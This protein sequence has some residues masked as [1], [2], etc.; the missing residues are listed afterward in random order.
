MTIPIYFFQVGNAQISIPSTN[1]DSKKRLSIFWTDDFLIL[2]SSC[3]IKM[4][5]GPDNIQTIVTVSVPSVLAINDPGLFGLCGDCDGKRDD[6][7]DANGVDLTNDPD[8]DSKIS[9]SYS[10]LVSPLEKE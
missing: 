7:T 1:L 4:A 3:G 6:L 9:Q 10:V 8:K 5:F 2:N